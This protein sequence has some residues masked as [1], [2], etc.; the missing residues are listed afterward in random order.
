MAVRS[1]RMYLKVR[2][3]VIVVE[4]RSNSQSITSIPSRKVDLIGTIV[5]ASA[6]KRYELSNTSSYPEAF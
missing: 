6:C 5:E 1:T 2:R 4:F 3:V